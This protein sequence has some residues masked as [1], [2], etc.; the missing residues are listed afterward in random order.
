MPA[1]E[2][3]PNRSASPPSQ[4]LALLGRPVLGGFAVIA[5]A[6]LLAPSGMAAGQLRSAGRHPIS[7]PMIQVRK[8]KI[9]GSPAQIA[10]DV[11]I[12]AVWVAAFT[13]LVK[14]SEATQKVTATLKIRANSV[15][16][17]TKTATVWAIDV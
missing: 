13:R 8:I 7:A 11:R 16:V 5:T 15:A 3:G 9:G 17:D 4:R 10:I 12:H 14:I 1:E 6:A 2:H